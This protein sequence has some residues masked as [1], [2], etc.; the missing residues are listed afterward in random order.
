MI[1]EALE[2]GMFATNCY[3]VGCP[4]TGEG[5]VIDPGS[6]AKRII[7]EIRRLG[8]HIKYIINTHGHIDHTGANARVKEVVNAPILLHRAD[9]N[10]YQ[11]PGFG[12]GLVAG[13]R[14]VPDHFISEGEIIKFGNIELQVIETPGHT[15]GGVSLLTRDRVFTGDTLFAGSIGRTDL[16]GGSFEVLIRSIRKRLA[17]LPPETRIYPGHGPNS[18]I[19]RELQYNPFITW[20]TV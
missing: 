13:K 18:T 14:P 19:A 17:I 7:K 1:L 10:I 12:L 20:G 5:T 4:D 9:L 8:L 3:L 16:A 11:N 2:V 6:D 15:P